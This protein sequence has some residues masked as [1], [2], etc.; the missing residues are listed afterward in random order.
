MSEQ[1]SESDTTAEASEPTQTFQTHNALNN[2]MRDEDNS[3]YDEDESS[4]EEHLT[5][6]ETQTGNGEQNNIQENKLLTTN[7]EVKVENQS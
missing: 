7:L 3:T 1:D 6:I 5:D 4:D 2:R